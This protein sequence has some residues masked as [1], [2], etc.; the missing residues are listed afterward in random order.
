MSGV[1][2]AERSLGLLKL[3]RVMTPS[4]KYESKRVKAGRGHR[5]GEYRLADGTRPKMEPK[6]RRY[7]C[8]YGPDNPAERHLILDSFRQ[9]FQD[10][11]LGWCGNGGTPMQPS[12][13]AMPKLVNEDRGHHGYGKD[14][15]AGLRWPAP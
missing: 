1:A 3:S 14:K 6:R 2:Q 13:C 12:H 9:R 11:F 5:A 8:D 15:P 4:R 10:V 7:E